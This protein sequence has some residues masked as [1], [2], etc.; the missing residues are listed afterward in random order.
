MAAPRGL[1]DTEA[2]IGISADTKGPGVA[3]DKRTS[4]ASRKVKTGARARSF[5]CR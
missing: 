3:F 1:N 2:E 5:P 4:V